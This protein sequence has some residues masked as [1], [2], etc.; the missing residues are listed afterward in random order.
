MYG[1]FHLTIL[2]DDRFLISPIHQMSV[3][4]VSNAGKRLLLSF[5]LITLSMP[6]PC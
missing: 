5:S 3:T 6:F 4:I 2:P 1:D